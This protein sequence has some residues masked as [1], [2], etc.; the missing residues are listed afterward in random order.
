MR[1]NKPNKRI[2]ILCEG[3]TEY[4]Y[5]KAL[6]NQLPRS[7]QRSVNIEIDFNSRNDPHSLAKEAG[8]RKK[9]AKKEN[10]PYDSI[11][12]FFDNDNWSQLESAFKIIETEKF[13]IAYSSMC[14]EH[15]FILHFED[16][17]RAFQNGGE[18]ITYL[19]NHWPNYHKTKLKHYLLLKEQLPT[20]MKRAKIRRKNIQP[21]FPKHTRNPYFTVDK[22]IE[23]FKN[24]LEKGRDL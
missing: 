10:N 6:Q 21:D 4:L 18:A 17:G 13:C 16:C 1:I 20:A 19:K 11:W 7:L 12:L 24:I 23:F 5:A 9:K 8:K 15:W 2:L 14:I 3:V 22:L